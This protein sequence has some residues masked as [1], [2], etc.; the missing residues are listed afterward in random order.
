MRVMS[1]EFTRL[2]LVWM[3][4]VALSDLSHVSV[5]NVVDILRTRPE[6]P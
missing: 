1:R 3:R 4:T 2:N 5:D 6:T